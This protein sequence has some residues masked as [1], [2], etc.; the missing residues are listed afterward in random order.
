MDVSSDFAILGAGLSLSAFF[1]VIELMSKYI[2]IF[3]QGGTSP[4]KASTPITKDKDEKTGQEL[5]YEDIN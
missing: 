2:F 3:F 1:F 4:L 5:V